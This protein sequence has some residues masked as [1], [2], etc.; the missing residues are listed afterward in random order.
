[1]LQE[2]RHIDN[3][4]YATIAGNRGTRH[5]GRTVQHFAERFDHNF[6][7]ANQLIH[8][9]PDLFG[10]NG[11][12]NHMSIGRVGIALTAFDQPTLQME[13]REH[14]FAHNDT[15]APV[16]DILA[17]QVQMEYLDHVD[18]RQGKRLLAELDHQGR[19]YCQGQ[20]DLDHYA[21]TTAEFR[22]N[23]KRSIEL[24]DFGFHHIHTDAPTRHIGNHVLGGEAGCE[25]EVEAFVLGQT[26]RRL[27]LKQAFFDGFTA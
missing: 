26:V 10:T 14:P 6:F 13:Q 7:L 5:S 18:E 15:F 11:N 3:Q 19:H 12:N 27:L 24:T 25:N 23:E 8:N 4:R 16:D 20:R 21:R 1:M 2:A 22:I 9:E 17:G